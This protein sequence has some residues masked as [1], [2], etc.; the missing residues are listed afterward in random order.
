M[1]VACLS[2]VTA[3]QRYVTYDYF[4]RTLADEQEV[5]G[6]MAKAFE[7]MIT[8]IQGPAQ[9]G[10]VAGSGFSGTVWETAH[11]AGSKDYSRIT[12][13]ED[14]AWVEN[15]HGITH[16]GHW[17]P[18]DDSKVVEIQMNSGENVNGHDVIHYK[19]SVDGGTCARVE[20][21]TTWLR[22]NQ[23]G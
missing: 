21:P 15:W 2:D 17:K 1:K 18:T 19:M 6:E 9:A 20:E 14:G 16:R 23:G 22:K 12:F 10:G 8:A 5:R 7:Q 4:Q 13:R 3:A 11:A